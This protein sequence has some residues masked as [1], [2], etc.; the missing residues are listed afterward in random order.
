MITIQ[1]AIDKLLAIKEK[2]GN[3][4]FCIYD[5]DYDEFYDVPDITAIESYYDDGRHVA[6][7]ILGA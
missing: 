7:A 4:D 2:Y 3:I 5:Y 6:A 1:E